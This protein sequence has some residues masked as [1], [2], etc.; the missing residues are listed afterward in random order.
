MSQVKTA[1]DPETFVP[2]ESGYGSRILGRRVPKA[3]PEPSAAPPSAEPARVPAAAATTETRIEPFLSPTAELPQAPRNIQ[4]LREAH[5]SFVAERLASAKSVRSG[6]QHN[7]EQSIKE[8]KDWQLGAAPSTWFAGGLREQL[9][10][11]IKAERE[12]LA[13]CD[14]KVKELEDRG[15]LSEELL[16]TAQ[17]LSAEAQVAER[18]GDAATAREK[19]AVVAQL[20]EVAPAVLEMPKE[21]FDVIR[22]RIERAVG[23]SRSGGAE[24]PSARESLAAARAVTA[25]WNRTIDTETGTR[26]RLSSIASTINLQRSYREINKGLEDAANRLVQTEYLLTTGVV[27]AVGVVAAT[28]ASGGLALPAILGGATIGTSFLGGCVLGVLAGTAVGAA[29]AYS[30]ALGNLAYGKSWSEVADKAWADTKSHF[31][32]ALTSVGWAKLASGVGWVLGKGG[33]FVKEA[34]KFAGNRLYNLGRVTG[35]NGAFAEIGRG[36]SWLGTAIGNHIPFT[37]SIGN[38]IASLAGQIKD[39]GLWLLRPATN[40]AATGTTAGSTSFAVTV[41]DGVVDSYQ[42][43]KE[44]EAWAATQPE[45]N[46]KSPTFNAEKYAEARNL[47]FEFNEIGWQDILGR[48]SKNGLTT[49]MSA[50][51]FSG[52]PGQRNFLSERFNK[53]PSDYAAVNSFFKVLDSEAG[54]HAA[55]IGTGVTIEYLYDRA[56]AIVQHHPR[57]K[58]V[59]LSPT[60][61]VDEADAMRITWAH[62]FGYIMGRSQNEAYYGKS[63]VAAAPKTRSYAGRR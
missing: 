27:I 26:P 39:W 12:Y 44:F 41:G 59:E 32:V 2:P 18:S 56:K 19:N 61:A 22:G 37:R 42:G 63:Y 62:M 43:L 55:G 51:L 21:Q 25:E 11:Q 15:K 47:Y 3:N 60:S 9:R 28:V 49:A 31:M 10:A 48:A 38:G 33:A 13:S 20:L 4:E 23:A 24:L 8:L 16:R 45:L 57:A 5:E 34:F 52:K 40:A 29:A 6:T 1:S 35:I 36:L 53:K 50:A 30:E 14:E 7:L 46:R 54:R 58:P 17:Q